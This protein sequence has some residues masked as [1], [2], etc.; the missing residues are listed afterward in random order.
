MTSIQRVLA[1][2]TLACSLL[3]AIGRADDE[4]AALRAELAALKHDYVARVG[5]LEARIEQLAAA[6]AA[7]AASSSSPATAF[8]PAISL[9]LAG[10]YTS[11]SQDP[12]AGESPASCRVEARSVRAIAVS[13]SPSPN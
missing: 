5:A 2:L 13:I 8:N 1:S 10:N 3:P 9:I 7:P 12:G 11:L 6:T 4:V